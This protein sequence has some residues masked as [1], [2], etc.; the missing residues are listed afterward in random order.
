MKNY[1]VSYSGNA[2]RLKKFSAIISANSER[3]AAEIAYAERCD[4]NYFPVDG[5]IFDCDGNEVASETD[6]NIWYD[7]GYF[8]AE[9]VECC[10]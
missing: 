1:N 2:T 5:K 8:S 9:E 3:E 6:A 7:G 4:S 10:D